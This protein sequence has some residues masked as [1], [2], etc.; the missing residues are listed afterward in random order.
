MKASK[1]KMPYDAR[2]VTAAK[3]KD[4]VAKERESYGYFTRSKV[5]KTNG[6]NEIEIFEKTLNT[7]LNDIRFEFNRDKQIKL[8]N[9]WF[10]FMNLYKSMN[11]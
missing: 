6:Q 8:L 2:S 5:I 7:Y 1:T 10:E 4:V 11:K 9:D 3:E